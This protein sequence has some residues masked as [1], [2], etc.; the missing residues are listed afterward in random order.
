L[1]ILKKHPLFLE[2][3]NLFQQNPDS[4]KRKEENSLEQEKIKLSK[5]TSPK[6]LYQ[7]GLLRI[8][9]LF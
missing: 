8:N 7:E 1:W 2:N 4:E 6:T 9:D 3:I 5:N